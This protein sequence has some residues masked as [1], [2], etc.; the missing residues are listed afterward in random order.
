M[1]EIYFFTLGKL[2]IFNCDFY[3]DKNCRFVVQ[4]KCKKFKEFK[5]VFDCYSDIKV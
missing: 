3:I 1:D 5:P 2:I 4:R